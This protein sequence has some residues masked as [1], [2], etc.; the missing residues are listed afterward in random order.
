MKEPNMELGRLKYCKVFP[1]IGIARVGSSSD[2]FVGPELP[3]RTT[4][5]SGGYKDA[6][7]DIRRQAARFRIYAFDDANQ[8]LG[9][10]LA[11]E[12]GVRIEWRVQ[13]ANKKASWHEF[14]GTKAGLDT[15]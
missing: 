1:G 7:R 2:C 9:E 15:D 5:P 4:E 11:D 6:R 3:G 14:K 13:L 8:V 12:P 10:C